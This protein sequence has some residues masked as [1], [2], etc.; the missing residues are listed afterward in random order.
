VV[1]QGRRGVARPPRHAPAPHRTL[2]QLPRHQ[3][4]PPAAL[5]LQIKEQALAEFQ[6]EQE[7]MLAMSF[8][9]EA[10]RQR[11]ADKQSVSFM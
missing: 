11:Y 5:V 7:K 9:S 8:M 1:R 4:R 2:Q 6:A 10:D 3:A